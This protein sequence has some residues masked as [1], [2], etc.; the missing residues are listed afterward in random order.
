MDEVLLLAIILAAVVLANILARY[1]TK[2]PLPFFL[3]FLGV[4]LAGL[5]VYKNFHLDPSTF[6]LAVIAPMLFNEAQNS[7]RLWIG[8]SITNI[9]SLA[10]GLVLVSVLVVGAGLHMVYTVLPIS[11]AF[12]LLAIV[13]PTDASAVNSIFESNPIAEEQ[14]GILQHE[15][16]FNDAAGIV[17]F[18]MSLA[19]FISGTFSMELAVGMF[20]WEFLGGL[21]FGSL[22]GVLIVSVRLFLIRY[23]NDTPLIMVLIQL[24][25]P[26]LVYLLAEKL[27]L[28]GILAV[29]AA[30]LAQGSEREKLRL[31]SSRMQLI[32]SNV[33]E[34]IS[35]MLSGT[36]FVL[37]GLSLPEVITA[38]QQ[39]PNPNFG[40]YKLIG[41]GVLLYLAKGI[42][43]LFWSRYLIKRRVKTSHE[44]RDSLVMAFSGANGT[45]TLS[46]AF[47]MPEVIHG[48]PFE[49]RGPMIFLAAVV[50]F[51]SLIMPTIFVPLLLPSQDNNQPRYRWVRRML[52]AAISD[53]VKEKEHPEEAQI[54][55]DSLQQ[56]LVLDGT[57]NLKLRRRLMSESHQVE[58][59]AV[60]KLH[61]DG[62]ITDDELFYYG[63]FL[64][65]NNFS[66][67][68]KIWKNVLLRIRF[69][70]HIG[71]LYKDMNRAQD[72][73]LTAP[74]ILE[75]VYWREQFKKHGE[76]ILPIEQVGFDAVMAFLKTKDVES[77]VESN[78]VKRFYRTRHRRIHG[79][80]VNADIVY[81]MF[82]RAFHSE[83]ELI[84]E[85]LSTGKI[86]SSLAEKLQQRISIDEMTYLQNTEI[87][88]N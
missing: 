87:F 46:L 36:V 84:Q 49:F 20:L 63:K 3:I 57:P 27:A 54:V 29:V 37:L 66:A 67:D 7:S 8:R 58:L 21:L 65:L 70:L 64:Q 41:I 51:I 38:M 16:L 19:A 53:L 25:T 60:Q 61:D 32:T 33:W 69:S 88:S 86:N 14:A 24:L 17:V 2:I 9:L 31:T 78:M 76:D 43:R 30:G 5:P 56:Q 74:V 13:T 35:G 1:F 59:R 45:I 73:F 34:I 83:Y 47:S 26:F 52:Q 79:K 71:T 55:I 72:A 82:M 75:E 18:D 44:W 68:E 48:Q 39:S 81:Q 4:L 12:A 62:K 42:I 6:A 28:S 11:L 85:A 22:I 50:I 80:D 77:G 10:V 15:S 40:V 23:N